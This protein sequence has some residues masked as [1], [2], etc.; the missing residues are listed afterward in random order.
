MGVMRTM[1]EQAFRGPIPLLL[2]YTMQSF[3]R[4]RTAV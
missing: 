2:C 1:L 3:E 4:W